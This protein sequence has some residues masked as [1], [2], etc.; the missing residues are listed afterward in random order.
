MSEIKNDNYILILGF[1]VNDLH[2]KGNELL[3]YACIYGF[4]QTENQKYTGRLQYLANWTN[5]TKQGVIKSINSL[6][7]KGLICKDERILNGVKFCE[8]YVS[9]FTSIKQSLT[10]IKQSLPN[11]I[12]NNID[13]NKEKESIKE[14]EKS[15]ASSMN[16]NLLQSGKISVDD[17]T[18][19]FISTYKLY[20]RKVSKERA[21]KTF[22]KKLCG[23]NEDTALEKARTIY[24][25]LQRQIQLWSAE[26]NGEGRAK[27]Y[28][29]HLS[30]WLN[31]NFEDSNK[32]R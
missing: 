2:L 23:L 8:Y 4:S 9:E 11:N 24:R 26:N 6:I 31:D 29:P 21:K 30:T 5:S 15:V 32:R 7:S 27:E 22:E 28:M 25:T 20:P 18:K 13:N 19:F 1:M 17:I 16:N 12:Y 3:I 10:G 14:K